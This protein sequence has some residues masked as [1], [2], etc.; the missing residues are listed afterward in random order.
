MQLELG[1]RELSLITQ[2]VEARISELGPEIRR[3]DNRD[4]HDAL[5]N[6]REVLVQL[7]QQLHE[8]AW[9]PTC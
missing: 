9:D 8:C 6:D 2:L 1:Q 5:K 3:S 4:F 7:V